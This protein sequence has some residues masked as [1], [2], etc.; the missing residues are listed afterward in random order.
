MTKLDELNDLK[1]RYQ[2]L[3]QTFPLGRHKYD[4]DFLIYK[5][6]SEWRLIQ[7]AD[8]CEK[9]I[10]DL[11]CGECLEAYWFLPLVNHWHSID[12]IPEVI[13][14]LNENMNNTFSKTIL[15][16]FTASVRDIRDTKIEENSFDVVLC[17]SVLEHFR[18][19]ED[20]IRTLNEIH[21]IMKVGGRGVISVTGSSHSIYKKYSERMIKEGKFSWE[22]AMEIKDFINL[23]E[24]CGFLVLETSSELFISNCAKERLIEEINK[25][26]AP[27][28][29]R[30]G[31]LIEK[32]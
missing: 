18:N 31:F 28:G 5:V 25:A 21:R 30:V 9:N 16:R 12:F 17:L 15:D 20:V 19:Y 26:I 14:N 6:V 32:K 22:K 10:L 24:S 29:S 3:A 27:L 13:A 7:Q 4:I 23:V 1:Q 8:I 2:L 11:G